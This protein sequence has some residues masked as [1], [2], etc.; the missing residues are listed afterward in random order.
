MIA[1]DWFSLEPEKKIFFDLFWLLFHLFLEELPQTLKIDE[2]MYHDSSQSRRFYTRDDCLP[3]DTTCPM[4]NHPGSHKDKILHAKL[5][6][7]TI[8]SFTA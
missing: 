3:E 7:V 4:R 6:S 5:I 1:Y 2:L 8:R